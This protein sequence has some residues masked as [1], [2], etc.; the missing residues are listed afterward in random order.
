MLCIFPKDLHEKPRS[1]VLDEHFPLDNSTT[2]LG[3]SF[4]AQ[5]VKNKS[6]FIKFKPAIP[7]IEC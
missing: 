2:L 4:F 6:K 1:N 3:G 5:F 7:F